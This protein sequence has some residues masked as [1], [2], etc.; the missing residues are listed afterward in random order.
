MKIIFLTQVAF[1]IHTAPHE[2]L[3]HLLLWFNDLT[4]SFILCFLLEL[5]AVCHSGPAPPEG[6]AQSKGRHAFRAGP[7]WIFVADADIKGQYE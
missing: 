1:T 7:I 2:G 5:A 6:A 4:M 3:F